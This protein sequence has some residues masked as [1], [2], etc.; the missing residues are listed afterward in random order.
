[1]A[2][3]A[4]A[5]V[6]LFA[7]RVA[8]AMGRGGEARRRRP[9]PRERR[10]QREAA[11]AGRETG[12]QIPAGITGGRNNRGQTRVSNRTPQRSLRAHLTPA[13]A[14]TTTDTPRAPS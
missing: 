2:E 7:R 4:I 1:E 10:D 9:L 5:V 3:A 11:K 14:R 6:R 8:G 13:F 12:D